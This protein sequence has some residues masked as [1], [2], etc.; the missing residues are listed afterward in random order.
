MKLKYKLA[1][2]YKEL[3]YFDPEM[4]HLGKH[5]GNKLEQAYVAGF[6]RCKLLHIDYAQRFLDNPNLK[7]GQHHED[8][9]KQFGEQ[10]YK[11]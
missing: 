2:K 10:E 1:K 9:F 3:Q 8:A 6:D 7:A 5:M 4:G 11:D